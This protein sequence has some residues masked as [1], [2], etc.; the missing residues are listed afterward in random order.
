MHTITEPV[1]PFPIKQL[2]IEDNKHSE[3]QNFYLPVVV[4]RLQGKA[5]LAS[6]IFLCQF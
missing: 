6:S 1:R 4:Q 2:K 5:Q 3:I